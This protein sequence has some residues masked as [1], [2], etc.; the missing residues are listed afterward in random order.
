MDNFDQLH[1]DMSHKYY[2]DEVGL[3]SVDFT[4]R[5]GTIY[6]KNV[7]PLWGTIDDNL[8]DYLFAYYDPT[9][10]KYPEDDPSYYM[11]VCID[12]LGDRYEYGHWDTKEQLDEWL[13]CPTEDNDLYKQLVRLFKLNNM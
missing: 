3:N 8:D 9:H 6:Y 5:D 11:L 10:T 7:Y 12:G 13:N 4:S 2:D 1:Y